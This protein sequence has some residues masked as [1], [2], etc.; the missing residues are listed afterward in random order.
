MI[1]KGY[2]F[3]MEMIVRAKQFGMF[4]TD[5][6]R[7]RTT[8]KTENLRAAESSRETEPR[9]GVAVDITL[10]LCASLFVAPPRLSPSLALQE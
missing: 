6:D 5:R 2:V 3:Q 9:R 8:E 7:F 1:S 10:L 4:F